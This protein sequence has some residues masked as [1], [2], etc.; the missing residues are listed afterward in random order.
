MVNIVSCYIV[1]VERVER[2]VFYG[3]LRRGVDEDGEDVLV[4]KIVREK[5]SGSSRAEEGKSLLLLQ[6]FAP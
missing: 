6:T 2:Y 5:K 4:P 1:Q 3:R